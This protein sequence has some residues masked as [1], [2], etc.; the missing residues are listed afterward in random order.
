VKRG[1]DWRKKEKFVE[2][3][4]KEHERRK[5]RLRKEEHLS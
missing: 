2:T 3:T 5:E 1:Q 4:N